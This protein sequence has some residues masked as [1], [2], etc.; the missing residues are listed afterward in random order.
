MDEVLPTA[1]LAALAEGAG[2]EAGRR[3]VEELAR[4]LA[5]DPSPSA[6]VL[7]EAAAQPA[8]QEAVR[9]WADRLADL[10]VADPHIAQ[11]VADAMQRHTPGSAESWYRGDHIDFRGG[12]FLGDVVGTQVVIQQNGPAEPDPWMKSDDYLRHV[13]KGAVYSHRWRLVG[14]AQTMD[15]LLPFARNEQGGVALLIGRAGVGKTK[16][17]TALCEALREADPA[18]EV[19]VLGPDSAIGPGSFRELPSTG[20]LLV[21]VDDAHDDALPLEKIVSGVRR[22]N[23]SAKR[24]SRSR[25]PTSWTPTPTESCTG[26]TV[27]SWCC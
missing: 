13:N 19:R 12:V 8:R 2:G 18:V 17:V 6:Q 21:I 24:C 22:A 3:L 14:R 15:G 27:P 25:T 11:A 26:S 4:A 23:G 5:Q 16:I 10:F 7:A 20:S 9:S 1:L